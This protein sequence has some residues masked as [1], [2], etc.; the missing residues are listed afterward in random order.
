MNN[1][2]VPKVLHVDQTAI[3][4]AL[5]V[6]ADFCNSL[7]ELRCEFKTIIGYEPGL[8]TISYLLKNE[9]REMYKFL[10][11]FP[12]RDFNPDLS[13]A[14]YKTPDALQVYFKEEYLKQRTD[15][16]GIEVAGV[17]IN[18]QKMLGLID[19]P[20]FEGIISK[21]RMAI[22]L[23]YLVFGSDVHSGI[24]KNLVKED[25]TNIYAN[26]IFNSDLLKEQ[27]LERFTIKTQTEEENQMVEMLSDICE[28]LNFLRS[29]E[30]KLYASRSVRSGFFE[31]IDYFI[32][33]ENDKFVVSRNLLTRNN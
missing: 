2:F 7:N 28:K 29:R 15:A 17:K 27:V 4:R 30:H 20:S 1:K 16:S 11:N 8:E 21:L 6:L 18:F 9:N 3:D 14:A 13:L 31:G 33:L 10:R 26:G 12:A 25:L 24:L 23:N 19:F 22:K 32:D 5:T